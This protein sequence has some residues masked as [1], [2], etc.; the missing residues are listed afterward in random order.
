[1]GDQQR[2]Y[3]CR[4]C[5]KPILGLQGEQPEEEGH[6]Y[7]PRCL[8]ALAESYIE[9]P[10]PE[11]SWWRLLRETRAWRHSMYLVAA[12]SL[13]VV[14]YRFPRFLASWREL[15][16]IRSGGIY[17]TDAKTDECIA[18]LWRAIQERQQRK[19]GAGAPP[20]CPASGRPY[21]VVPGTDPEIHCPD[22]GRH[23][24]RDIV[25]STSR[26]VPELKR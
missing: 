19:K 1:M 9:E 25:V 8:I 14:V 7:C 6:Y 15:P 11:K 17:A 12:V 3:L 18:N 2:E 16:P 24:F 4:S 26:P 13:V 20:V 22:P 10:P 5:G 21:V 23:G